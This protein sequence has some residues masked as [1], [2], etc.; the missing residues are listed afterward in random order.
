M[1]GCVVRT[2]I[3]SRRGQ[4]LGRLCTFAIA[5]HPIACNEPRGEQKK[6]VELKQKIKNRLYLFFPPTQTSRSFKLLFA[7]CRRLKAYSRSS[8]PFLQAVT[9]CYR[10]DDPWPAAITSSR[11]RYLAGCRRLRNCRRSSRYQKGVYER[12][13]RRTLLRLLRPWSG[14][15]SFSSMP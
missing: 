15:R 10:E 3:G 7:P 12:R 6:R 9:L 5:A 1:V 14:R 11:D 8:L 4:T 13:E 2:N